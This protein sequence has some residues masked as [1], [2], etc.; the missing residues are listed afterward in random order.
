[1]AGTIQPPFGS[2][3]A[4]FRVHEGPK[5]WREEDAEY[6]SEDDVE[7]KRHHGLNHQKPLTKTTGEMYRFV[8]DLAADESILER[9]TDLGLAEEEDRGD[10]L[11]N[12]DATS[13]EINPPRPEKLDIA[14]I[15]NLI[16]E[17]EAVCGPV[18]TMDDRK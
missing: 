12:E 9:D 18:P 8:Q 2:S 10:D 14:F 4:H 3:R 6:D 1:M 13:E 5:R 11:A 16:D 7:R 15:N 17:M